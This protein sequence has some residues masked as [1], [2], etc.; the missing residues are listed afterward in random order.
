MNKHK[1]SIK[2]FRLV[3][4][5]KQTTEGPIK[6]TWEH[7]GKRNV[8]YYEITS[9]QISERFGIMNICFTIEEGK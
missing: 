9:Y 7:H 1:E 3:I 6:G 2:S 8:K 4:K 5:M